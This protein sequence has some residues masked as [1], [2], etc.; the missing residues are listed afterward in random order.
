[1]P[2][3][4][5]SRLV[6]LLAITTS[7][8]VSS[9]VFLLFQIFFG[10]SVTVTPTRFFLVTFVPVIV[11]SYGVL[12]GS[13]SRSGA[14]V[15]LWVGAVL[16]LAHVSFTLALLTFFLTSSKATRFREDQ[17]RRIEGAAHKPGGKR[18]WAQVLCNGGIATELA[19]LYLIDVGSADLPMDFVSHYRASWLGAA[20]LGA[21]SCCNGDTW[22]SELGSVWS[23]K[24]PWLV[25]SLRRV[26]R[27]TN[28]A[29]SAA[30]LVFSLAGGLAIGAAYFAGVALASPPLAPG[31][32]ALWR[33]QLP[34]V[35]L[36]GIAGLMG[37]L[38]DS[39][40]GATLQFSG[41]DE[42]TGAIVDQ[43]GPGVKHVSGYPFLD[44]HAI[45]LISS[46]ATALVMPS[47][48]MSFF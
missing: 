41:L 26:P 1:M 48:A 9:T 37:S 27:G 16:T 3:E 23:D 45:N 21:L 2:S 8:C 32:A 29:V 42:S 6:F 46:V 39:L 5:V 12:R 18:D 34:V 20:V 47:I 44:N 17:K 28:G 36:G 43:P 30:G 11:T 7:V 15:A 24:S 38:I 14:V 13:L 19:L 4:P 33:T 25:T 40:L 22:A 31:G 35:L 10:G